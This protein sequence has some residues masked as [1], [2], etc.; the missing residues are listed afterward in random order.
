MLGGSGQKNIANEMPSPF[1]FCALQN[2][3]A[4]GLAGTTE[5]ATQ[6]LRFMPHLQP[7]TLASLLDAGKVQWD[8]LA[9]AVYTGLC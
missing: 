5:M 8:V 9:R 3:V 2:D 1:L 4:L 6:A 7:P